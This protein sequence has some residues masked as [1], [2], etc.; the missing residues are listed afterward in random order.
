[1]RTI[2]TIILL[3][4]G[5]ITNAQDT[6]EIFTIYLVRHAEKEQ[7]SDNPRDP[8]LTT[9]GLARAKSLGTFLERVDVEEIY[10]TD[11]IRTKST[12]QPSA[13][14]FGKT[15]T[16]YDP[17]DLSNFSK[18]LIDQG[19]SALVI[20]HSNTTGVL[21]GL[22]AGEDLGAF[23]EDVYDRIY[24]VIVNGETRH[25]QIFQSAFECKI[26]GKI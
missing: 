13:D 16:L 7:A 10:S 20:G 14:A 3:G 4:V 1:M 18:Q 15:I 5:Q 12:A 21:A 25:L 2:F 22:L 23:D 17:R 19:K 9:C 8:A 24:Q 11:Y 6:K 26:N